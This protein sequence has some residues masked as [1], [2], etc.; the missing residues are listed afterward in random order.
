[1]LDRAI[2]LT[3]LA[4]A[5][6]VGLWPLTPEGW[7]KMPAWVTLSGIGLGILLIGLAAGMIIADHKTPQSSQQ[8][9]PEFHLAID[10]ANVFVPDAK[11]DLTGIGLD[12][13][14]WNTGTASPATGWAMKIIP[15]GGQPISSQLTTL[16]N[17]LSATGPFNSSRMLAANSL[18]LKTN[19]NNVGD[20]PI[21][22]I[23]LFYVALPQA[24]VQAPETVWELTVRDI[25]EKETTIRQLVGD[26]LQR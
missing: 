12:A 22:G 24:I 15:N 25:H 4:L 8:Q 10:S 3:G 19:N 26:W 11:P 17:V 14:I 1:M 18:V 16:P 9:R 21:A 2:G 7:P 6:I 5:L 23:L 13:R 20:S